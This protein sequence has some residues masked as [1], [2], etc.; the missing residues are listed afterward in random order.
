MHRPLTELFIGSALN[1]VNAEG[2]RVPRT[3]LDSASSTLALAPAQDAAQQFLNFHSTSDSA[4]HLGANICSDALAWAQKT[5]I[6]F[7]GADAEYCAVFMGAGTTLPLN[8]LAAGLAKLRP[9]HDVVLLSLME[10]NS[11]DL[12]HRQNASVI[13]VTPYDAEGNFKG[14][15]L[16]ALE[17]LLLENQGRVNYIAV[18]ACSNV[19]GH[20]IPIYD[21]AEKAH[22]YGA[23]IIVDASQL[24]PHSRLEMVQENAQRSLDFLVLSGNKMY[25]PGAPGVLVARKD[26]LKK[27]EPTIW[28]AGMAEDVSRSS[29]LP[30]SNLTEREH[31]GSVD[32]PGIISL[33]FTMEF[34]FNLGMDQVQSR[35]DHVTQRCI[36]ALEQVKDVNVYTFSCKSDMLG[37][38]AFNLHGMSHE[39]LARILNDYFAIAV[40]NG[41]FNAFPFVLECLSEELRGLENNWERVNYQGM[42]RVS[43]GLYS[44]E[45]DVDSLVNAVREIALNRSAFEKHY[46]KAYD[47]GFIHK[48]FVMAPAEP[49]ELEEYVHSS[50][51][52][53]FAQMGV[54]DSEKDLSNF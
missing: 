32:M 10:Q 35:I 26:I 17:E 13:H 25:A 42:V 1:V 2:D 28:G 6:K 20:T 36:G 23:Y 24:A 12:P 14:L 49:W 52:S 7:V 9:T 4:V 45:S 21:V 50:I 16:E 15:D 38:V 54:E 18:T 31:V 30:A 46:I 51:E 40:G 39:L 44:N 37:V 53:M 43:F 8:R 29:F 22:K 34:L 5:A 27:M 47:G 41:N 19:T 33:A 3:Y 48:S 11:N